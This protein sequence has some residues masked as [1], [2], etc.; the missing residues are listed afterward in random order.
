MGTAEAAWKRRQLSQ[1]PQGRLREYGST[2]D[3]GNKVMRMRQILVRT[4][5]VALASVSM[6]AG[7]A[8]QNG[9][10]SIAGTAKDEAKKPYTDYSVRARTIQ[11]GLVAMTATLDTDGAFA[12]VG[13]AQASYLVEL[14]NRDGKVVCTEGPFDLTKQATR[15]DVVVNCAKV[16]VAWWLLGAAAAAGVTAGVV[17]AGPASAAQ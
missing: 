12:L 1:L 8:A 5:V 10:A 3:K 2:C 15:T 4:L 9:P 14:L 17:A 7:Q 11:Q 6:P 13:L 16:P